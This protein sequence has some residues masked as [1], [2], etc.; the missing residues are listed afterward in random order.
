MGS[1][2]AA[3]WMMPTVTLWLLELFLMVLGA[4]LIVSLAT[5][6]LAGTNGRWHIELHK[7]F[8]STVTYTGKRSQT[9][10]AATDR[11]FPPAKM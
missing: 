7:S 10:N 5:A 1:S 6:F 11:S 2:K 3:T 4:V 9:F 8:E